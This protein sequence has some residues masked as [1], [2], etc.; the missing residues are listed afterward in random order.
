M[1]N[2]LGLGSLVFVIVIMFGDP[3]YSGQKEKCA[4][5]AANAYTKVAANRLFYA[6]IN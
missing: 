6:C 1:K 5:E 2:I 4:S 3:A